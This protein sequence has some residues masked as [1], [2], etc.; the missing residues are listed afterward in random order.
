MGKGFCLRKAKPLLVC[1]GK[2]GI[3]ALFRVSYGI[4]H[5]K[6]LKG[7]MIRT[8]RIGILWLVI[9]CFAT[10]E[11]APVFIGNRGEKEILSGAFTA[12]SQLQR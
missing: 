2:F 3:L 12:V 11:K 10:I 6:S 7:N 9:V 4:Q 5:P 1:D 8:I